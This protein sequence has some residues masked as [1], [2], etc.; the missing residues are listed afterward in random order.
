MNRFSRSFCNGHIWYTSTPADQ[1]FVDLCWSF[2]ASK[3]TIILVPFNCFTGKLPFSNWAALAVSPTLYFN[4]DC[5]VFIC[6]SSAVCPW[7]NSFPRWYT[8]MLPSFQIPQL[9]RWLDTY[10]WFYYVRGSGSLI[11]S[12]CFDITRWGPVRFSGR[13]EICAPGI[14]SAAKQNGQPLFPYP[15]NSLAFYYASSRRTSSSTLSIRFYRIDR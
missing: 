5:F 9:S 10:K 15:A 8:P 11:S 7:N 3:S 2:C 13:P 6:C 1:Q 12:T 4:A 14:C